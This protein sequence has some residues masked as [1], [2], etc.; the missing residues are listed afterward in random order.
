M[1]R[2][3]QQTNGADGSAAAHRQS[4][5]PVCLNAAYED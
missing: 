4:V 5:M 2:V 3:A 1:E